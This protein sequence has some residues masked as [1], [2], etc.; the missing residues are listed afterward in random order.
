MTNKAEYAKT[1]NLKSSP[2]VRK[3]I[4]FS[5]KVQ[6][7]GFRYE[8]CTLAEQLNLTGWVENRGHNKVELEV[9]G[10]EDKILFLISHMRSLKRAVVTHVEIDEI[11]LVNDEKGFIVK[12][13]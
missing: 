8:I 7:V 12:R 11:P 5:G 3:R 2:I 9:Q 4:V 1:S 6:R 13:G 10:W